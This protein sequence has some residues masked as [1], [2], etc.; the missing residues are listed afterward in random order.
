MAITGQL[1]YIGTGYNISQSPH[2]GK[3]Y[4]IFALQQPMAIFGSWLLGYYFID[5]DEQQWWDIGYAIAT[6]VVAAYWYTQ[7][8]PCAPPPKFMEE[9]GVIYAC[10][11]FIKN[12]VCWCA[13]AWFG[14]EA[15]NFIRVLA[16]WYYETAYQTAY[17]WALFGGLVAMALATFIAGF[18]FDS[19]RKTIFQ[20]FTLK[21]VVTMVMVVL[22][23]Y[24]Y[25]SSWWS[26]T[27]ILLI[28][29]W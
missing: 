26:V 22:N 10:Q 25:L 18:G 14:V 5:T 28:T 6:L 9:V 20:L 11:A 16:P 2:A 7:Q 17:S 23:I 1:A 4:C 3:V 15:M 8:P 21:A 27:A 13:A 24:V 19:R 12:L 29:S